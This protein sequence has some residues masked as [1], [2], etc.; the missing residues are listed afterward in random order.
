M[1]ISNSQVNSST[2]TVP[3]SVY[4]SSGTNAIT[5]IALCNTQAVTLTDE[6]ANSVNVNVYLVASGDTAGADNLIVSNL[7]IQAGETVFFSDEKFVLEN[8]DAVWIGTS[9][10]NYIT[11][12]DSTLAV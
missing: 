3:V 2:I 7:T 8:N 5:T 1:A 9:Q 6:T 12:T 11:A 4:T 10:A